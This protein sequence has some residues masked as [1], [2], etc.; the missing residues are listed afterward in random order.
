MALTS[1]IVADIKQ[2]IAQSRENAVRAVDFQRVLM[3]WHIGKRIF[4]EEQQG[5]E[6]ADYGAYLI[7]SL[8]QQLQ[9]EFGS[10][11][12]PRQLERYRQF[13][14]IF[15][16]ASALRTQLNWT[17]YK[18]LIS[19]DDEDKRE[20]YIAESVKNNWSSRQLERQI[21]SQLYERLLL[22]NDKQSVLAVANQSM[23]P[24]D[25]QQIIKDPMILEFLGLQ[26]ESAYYEKDL[27]Q[28][29][30]THLQEFLLELGN[31]FSF[32]A[33]QKRLHLDGDDFF[34]DL[35]FYNRLLQCFVLIEMKTHKLTHQDLGQLQ[36]YVNYFD[37]VEKLPH[38]NP[39]IGILLCAD[40]NDSVVRFS[41]PENQTQIFASQYQLYL[42]TEK[43]L[44]R[45]IQKEIESFEQKK[46]GNSE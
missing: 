22:S 43:M 9:P 36:M 14:R 44:L 17:Q 6:R 29:I 5:Q 16:I 32:V 21:H 46:I 12:S 27:E 7:K 39:T 23:L 24:T 20:F 31:G 2:I 8:A 42:P 3:Y 26:R 33:R 25:P 30:I 35:V 45:E 41:L 10:G 40:K 13:Y 37:R 15:P 18:L 19:I 1:I 28:A 4:E 34:V 11:F 38:E